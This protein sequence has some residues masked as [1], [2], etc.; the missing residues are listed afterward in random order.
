MVKMKH[1]NNN[2]GNSLNPTS[3]MDTAE[4]ARLNL[5][6]GWDFP[7]IQ[8]QA[9]PINACYP[10][11]E[12]QWEIAPDLFHSVLDRISN[13]FR[14]SKAVVS[15]HEDPLSAEIQTLDFIELQLNFFKDSNSCCAQD[16]VFMSVQ[17]RRGDPIASNQ[18]IGR[19]LEAAKGERLLLSDSQSFHKA[20]SHGSGE[21]TRGASPNHKETTKEKTSHKKKKSK[22][23]RQNINKRKSKKKEEKEKENKPH[24]YSTVN[25][26]DDARRTDIEAQ[27]PVLQTDQARVLV[28]VSNTVVDNF[29]NVNIGA[30]VSNESEDENESEELAD[31]ELEL[32]LRCLC[33]WIA[34]DNNW[35]F[36]PIFCC[37][38]GWIGGLGKW[39][40]M[41][42]VNKCFQEVGPAALGS[43]VSLPSFLGLIMIILGGKDCMLDVI[44]GS[45][46]PDNHQAQS[47]RARHVL[48]FV[49]AGVST[50]WTG[51]C[52]VYN[53]LDNLCSDVPSQTPTFAPTGK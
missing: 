12:F 37:I 4:D 13:H 49:F 2:E 19:L 11:D 26:T 42:M 34:M 51:F 46:P 15:Y 16:N 9:K 28:D 22:R 20:R 36:Y 14:V 10:R 25:T 45:V 33:C 7:R 3:T 44:L 8:I 29:I 52:I 27:A 31:E 41:I 38:L 21:T 43:Y 1:K 48:I 39:S 18:C 35:V 6:G 17:R 24:S 53:A 23:I 32:P 30:S 5:Q 50:V 40:Y 47:Q